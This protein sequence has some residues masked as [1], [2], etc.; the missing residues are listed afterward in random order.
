MSLY[1]ECWGAAA[2]CVGVRK[3][4]CRHGSCAHNSGVQ[5]AACLEDGDEREVESGEVHLLRQFL[6]TVHITHAATAHSTAKMR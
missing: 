3:G 5:C 2:A 6:C 1:S 4:V